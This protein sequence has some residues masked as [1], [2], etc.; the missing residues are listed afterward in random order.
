[1][2]NFFGDLMN[3]QAGYFKSV[4]FYAICLLVLF[5]IMFL[6][7]RFFKSRM[8]NEI[9]SINPSSMGFDELKKMKHTGLLSDEEY[10]KIKSGLVKKFIKTLPGDVVENINARKKNEAVEKSDIQEAAKASVEIPDMM[11]YKKKTSKSG[12]G[13]IDIDTLLARGLISQEEYEKL[14]KKTGGETGN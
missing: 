4:T 5:V 3:F 2:V 1:M 9:Q 11:P 8:Q 7:L 14:A 6:I 10:K 13:I 12:P